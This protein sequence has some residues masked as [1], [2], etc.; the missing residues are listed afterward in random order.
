[1]DG[2]VLSKGVYTALATGALFLHILFIL[3]V[4]LGGFLGRSR[5]LLRA[6]HI[7]ALIWGILTEILPW[8]CPLTILENWLESMAGV[9]PY[10]GGFLLHYLDAIVYPNISGR[11]LMIGAVSVCVLNLAFY[12]RQFWEAGIQ[13]GRRDRK[14]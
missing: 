9:Q 11:V 7:A 8:P 3:W 12:A 1:M 5:P 10:Q 14:R 4:A 6:L 2:I 13:H